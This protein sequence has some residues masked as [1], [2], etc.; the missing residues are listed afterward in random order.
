[1]DAEAASNEFASMPYPKRKMPEDF[2]HGL[3]AN[4]GSRADLEKKLGQKV[5]IP[6]RRKKPRPVLEDEQRTM[7]LLTTAYQQPLE[8]YLLAKCAAPA[9]FGTKAK[10]RLPYSSGPCEPAA[11]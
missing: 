3:I 7:A 2:R 8:P 1:M 9:S 5:E 11:M 10:R 4:Y 6:G